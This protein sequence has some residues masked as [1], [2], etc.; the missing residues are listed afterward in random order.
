M[1][2][3]AMT[4]IFAIAYGAAVGL[5][6]KPGLGWFY[7]LAHN[8]VVDVATGNLYL[9]AAAHFVA[10]MVWALFYAYIVEPRLEGSGWRKGLLF[11]PLPWLLS[12]VVFLPL[13]GGGF[14]GLGIGAGPLPVIGNLILHLG[15]GVTL[16][17]LYSP[18]AG[19]ALDGSASDADRHAASGS[20]RFSAMGMV[21]GAVLGGIAGGLLAALG[22]RS[23]ADGLSGLAPA[24]FAVLLPITGAAW[25]GMVGSFIGLSGRRQ[26]GTGT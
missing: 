24:F 1:A 15:Y 13:V 26:E 9:A 4:F 10:G 8:R 16:G 23:G 14:F 25:G 22:G 17:A 7:A 18:Y 20:L 12:L 2:T 11:A 21:V 5:G 3:V 6:Q 19:P